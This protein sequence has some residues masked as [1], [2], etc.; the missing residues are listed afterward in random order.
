[1]I[2]HTEWIGTSEDVTEI[3]LCHLGQRMNKPSS[4]QTHRQTHSCV[5]NL[6][7]F[8]HSLDLSLLRYRRHIYM[9]QLRMLS[10]ITSYPKAQYLF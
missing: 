4:L 3:L 7:T 10:G 5:Y 8:L 2:R 6:Q 9:N 1:M